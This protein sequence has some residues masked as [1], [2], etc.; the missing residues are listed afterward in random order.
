MS[1]PPPAH[2]ATENDGVVPFYPECKKC[3]RDKID[4]V[5]CPGEPQEDLLNQ[6]P[7]I[8]LLAPQFFALKIPAGSPGSQTRVDSAQ[9]RL[10]CRGTEADILP[11][12]R[13]TVS[14]LPLHSTGSRLSSSRLV[15]IDST[16]VN[17]TGA[18]PVSLDVRGAVR[19]WLQQQSDR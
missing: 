4:T 9:L 2:S 16:A 3:C 8:P 1:P 11:S 5:R 14:H 18:G 6:I 19:R 10:Y 7:D 17:N 12:F 13:V 15:M